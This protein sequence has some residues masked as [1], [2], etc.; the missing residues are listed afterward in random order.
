ML[1]PRLRGMLEDDV[2][3]QLGLNV[4]E[5]ETPEEEREREENEPVP[6]VPGQNRKEHHS[7]IVT[8]NF[9]QDYKI[10]E[11]LN[12]N[13][14]EYLL[15]I[16]KV[17]DAYDFENL[18]ATT[19]AEMSAGFLSELEIDRLRKVMKKG[20]TN[21]K[22]IMEISDDI[23]NKV[24]VRDLYK[25]E[26]GVIKKID[27]EPVLQFSAEARAIAIARTETT[28]LANRGVIEHYKDQGVKEV[29]WVASLGDR[30]CEICWDLNGR[31]FPI[32]E[33]PVPG[34]YPHIYCRCT[35]VNI[36]E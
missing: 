3:L 2:A 7:N 17:T 32:G 26:N 16:L 10:N 13:Y 28:R 14:Q 18:A 23:K 11:W 24:K 34:D 5:L 29:V 33:A 35:L 25:M 8:E 31:T 27:G 12:F 6:I 20:F 19:V 21:E 1:N 9:K 36:E 22:T 15:A 4:K 30:T